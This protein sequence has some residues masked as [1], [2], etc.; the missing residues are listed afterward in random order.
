LS[1]IQ[2]NKPLNEIWLELRTVCA[3][4][5]EV[6]LARFPSCAAFLWNT[7]FSANKMLTNAEKC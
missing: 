1:F 7:M 2:T 3:T 5:P 6:F 4:I